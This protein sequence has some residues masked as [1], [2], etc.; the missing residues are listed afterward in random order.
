MEEEILPTCVELGVTLVAY[1]PLGRGLLTGKFTEDFE[2]A[3]GDFR[4]VGQPR[5]QEGNLE[6][7]L[8]LVGVVKRVAGR[9]DVTPAQVAL[10]WVLGRG[11]HVVAIPGTTSV[12]HL[13][14]NLA[15][16]RLELTEQDVEELDGLADRVRGARYNEAG[17]AALNR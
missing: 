10:A 4:R 13:D 15:A 2:A 16:L 1:S 14:T 7:N 9:H 12:K 3:D 5:F 17:M 6:A 11:D 8:E